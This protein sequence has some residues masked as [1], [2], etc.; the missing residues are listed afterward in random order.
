MLEK[1][2]FIWLGLLKALAHTINVLFELIRTTGLYGFITQS[3]ALM[4]A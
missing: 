3:H 2:V 1:Q 4:F